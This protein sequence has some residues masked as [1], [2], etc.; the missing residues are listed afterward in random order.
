[1]DLIG[2][3]PHFQPLLPGALFVSP[4]PPQPL[5]AKAQG[6]QWFSIDWAGDRPA[7]HQTGVVSARPVPGAFLN[8]LWTQTGIPPERTIVGGFSQGAMMALHVGTSLPANQTLMGVIGVSGAFLPPE[9]LGSDAL[10][11]P[12]ICLIHG[13][14]DEVVDPNSSA[15]A[16]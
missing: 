5:G 13:D 4:N 14:L 16:N 8:D 11:H 15:E 9:G 12:P 10:A 6:Y 2:L 7:S 3:A 1:N